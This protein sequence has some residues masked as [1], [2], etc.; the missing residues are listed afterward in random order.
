MYRQKELVEGQEIRVTVY[1][2][3]CLAHPLRNGPKPL[4]WPSR[5]NLR[6]GRGSGIP[7]AD[8]GV[9]KGGRLSDTV[10][11]TSTNVLECGCQI[12]LGASDSKAREVQGPEEF[13]HDVSRPKWKETA[14]WRYY[15]RNKQK[16]VSTF[17]FGGLNRLWVCL[18][19]HAPKYLIQTKLISLL[20]K[21]WYE[22]ISAVSF[23]TNYGFCRLFC[24]PRLR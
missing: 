16:K 12:S 1:F 18:K 5:V 11:W 24:S 21:A 17:I 2:D 6:S 4:H 19:L 13:W 7:P 14:V 3:V 8:G 20:S 10:F 23:N 22:F 15:S 9:E